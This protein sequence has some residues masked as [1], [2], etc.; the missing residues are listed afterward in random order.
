LEGLLLITFFFFVCF[1]F[2][3]WIAPNLIKMNTFIVQI[4]KNR[5]DKGGFGPLTSMGSGRIEN[6][7]S[8][9]SLSSTGTGFGSGSGFGLSTDV[10]SFSTKPKGWFSSIFTN[11]SRMFLNATT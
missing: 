7:L 1:N 6:S 3:I 5:G 4:E 2:Q 8:D 10:D 11:S 9:L